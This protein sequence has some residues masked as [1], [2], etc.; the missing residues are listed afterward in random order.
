VTE[1]VSLVL[2]DHHVLVAEGLGMLLATEDGLDVLDL[3]H[4]GGQV[5]ESVAKH[6]PT[7]LV[8]DAELPAGDLEATLAAAKAAAPA[9]RLL[10][11]SGDPHPATSAAVLAVGAD[12]CLA[13]D[14]SSRQV[15]AA[16]RH[17]AA[18]GQAPVAAAEAPAGRDPSVELQV[19]TLTPRQ[20]EFLGLLAIGWSN[21]RIAEATQLS[22]HTVRSHMH[23]LLLKLGVHSQLEAVAFAV[24]HGVVAVDGALQVGER[25]VVPSGCRYSPTLSDARTCQV[26]GFCLNAS[27]AVV[28]ERT[29]GVEPW[30]DQAG[31]G[32][33]INRSGRGQG[34]TAC[35]C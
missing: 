29:T 28:H 8:L 30:G 7:V 34:G 1:V 33:R 19:R 25:A 6:Q 22:Y 2:A 9:T 21:R 18:G 35:G 12:G 20:C 3:A 11:L 27:A 14:R 16:I 5:I 32:C 4:H 17:L 23:N 24:E 31:A 10:V 13:K 15:A 26:A